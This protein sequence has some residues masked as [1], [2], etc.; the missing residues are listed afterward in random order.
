MIAI[1]DYGAGNLRSVKKALT[2]I[3]EDCED[4]TEKDQ[5]KGTPGAG[6]IFVQPKVICVI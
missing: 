1:I 5:D 6:G 2:A 4:H 3:G